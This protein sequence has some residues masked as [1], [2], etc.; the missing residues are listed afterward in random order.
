[1]M[2]GVVVVESP[3]DNPGGGVVIAGRI[4]DAG[5]GWED[6]GDVVVAV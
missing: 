5:G 6:A 4:V 2:L 1:M 3:S